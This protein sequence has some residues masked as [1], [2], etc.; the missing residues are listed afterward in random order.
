MILAE[1]QSASS[2]CWHVAGWGC[3][4][5]RHVPLG[6][7]AGIEARE[8]EPSPISPLRPIPRQ[9]GRG[10]SLE[11]PWMNLEVLHTKSQLKRAAGMSLDS[12]PH[13]PEDV[14]R[15]RDK[16]LRISGFLFDKLGFLCTVPGVPVKPQ[17]SQLTPCPSH[18][19]KSSLWYQPVLL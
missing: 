9:K 15:C 4:T 8:V 1:R 3:G 5:H 13:V 17:H 19:G 12:G 14:Y 10:S 2:L 11:T 16:S 7:G 6:W 18:T